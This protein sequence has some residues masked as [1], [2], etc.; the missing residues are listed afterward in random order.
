MK[1]LRIDSNVVFIILSLIGAL[2]LAISV[3]TM[4]ITHMLILAS[5]VVCLNALEFYV[6]LEFADTLIV[7]GKVI[8]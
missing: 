6:M 2:M 7:M 1:V 4:N 8:K 3:P 5:S